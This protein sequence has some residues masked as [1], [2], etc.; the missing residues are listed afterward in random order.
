[1]IKH[2]QKRNFIIKLEEPR[3][4]DHCNYSDP[5]FLN[6]VCEGPGNKNNL[7]S[8]K[9]MLLLSTTFSNDTSLLNLEARKL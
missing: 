6:E 8:H 4:S 7:I 3:N 1:M 2:Q 9:K 5:E